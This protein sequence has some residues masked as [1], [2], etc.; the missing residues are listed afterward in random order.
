[1]E[2]VRVLIVGAGPSGLATS[3]YLNH[4]SISN[5]VLEKED[6]YA[7]LWKKRA[8]DRLCLHLAKDFCSLPLMSHSSSTPT[9][10]SRATFLKYLDEYVTKFNI[11][12]R[13]CRNVERAWLEDEEEDGEKKWRV[14]ARNIETGEMEAYKAEFL[15]VA[16]GENS[17]GYV[18]EVT[19]LDTFE[20]EIV[21][22]SNYK[23]GRGFEGKDVLVVGCGNSGMEIALDLSNYGAQPSIV[24]RNPLHVLKRE[25]VY[26]G[27][28]LMKYLPV[29]VVDAILVGLAKLKFGDM[30]AYGICRPKLGPMQLKFATGK[31]P[32]I[33]V[34]TISKIQ[35]GQIKV[36][37]QISNIDGET[38]EFE[39][40]V[41]RKFDAI[42]FATGYKSSANN[43]LKD[44]ELVLNEKG[45]PRSGIPKHWK[46]K[47]NVYCV[48][49]S[50]QGLAGV[51]FDA[52]AV[53]QDI[54]NSI[55]NKF[56]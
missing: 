44:Y 48:G 16:S 6:C 7:S 18:P 29:S 3:A 47:K 20:G 19:G 50:R 13:Y 14:E 1:M 31:T 24:I 52:K 2:E 25:M 55:S 15:V 33:D 32:V 4:L 46:G 53:A 23:S 5:I 26:V 49:L 42:V 21:H 17:V 43:W 54:S 10:M 56:K 11:R 41:R 28:L 37:P 45:M 34:G 35:D 27:M 36:V 9:F 8:Y 22:S 39:N 12:P 30:S 38:I 40:G 51:S